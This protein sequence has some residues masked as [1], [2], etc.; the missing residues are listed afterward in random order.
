M[1]TELFEWMLVGIMPA[2]LI[3]VLC[4]IRIAA[5]CTYAH[6]LLCSVGILSSSVYVGYT[7]G[8]LHLTGYSL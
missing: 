3:F 4:G 1:N 7:L 8:L 5:K 6:L 2:L